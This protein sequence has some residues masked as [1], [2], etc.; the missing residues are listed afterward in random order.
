MESKVKTVIFDL[1]G[2][3]L[4]TLEDLCAATNYA[5]RE[6]NYPQKSLEEVRLAVGNGVA[7]LI[8]RVIPEGVENPD[9]SPC[10]ECFRGYYSEHLQDRTAPYPGIIEMLQWL[11][12]QGYGIGIVSNKFDSAVKNLRDDYFKEYIPVAIGESS[13]VR[14]KPAPDCVFKAMKELDC[15]ADTAI[16]VGDSDVDIQTAHNAGLRC[17]G[18]SWGFRG[19]DFLV[20]NGADWIIV[21]PMEWCERLKNSL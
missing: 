14:K 5:L 15:T 18:V 21:K 13:D 2:T 17:V 9:F 6:F 20:A 7:K 1:D 16:Y 12:M 4:N 19:H 10:L 8:E 11:K 3:L